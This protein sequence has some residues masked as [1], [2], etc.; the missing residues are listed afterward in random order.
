MSQDRDEL[1]IYKRICKDFKLVFDIG[2]RDDLDYYHIHPLCEYHLFEPNEEAVNS[3]IYKISNIEKYRDN[4]KINKF[5]LSDILSNNCTYYKNTQSFVPHWQGLSVDVGV[6]YS[7]QTL[8][9]YVNVNNISDIDFI[10][11]DCEELDEM[12]IRGG[13]DT[14]KHNNKV[15]YLQF[16]Y[17]KIGPMVDLLDN[18]DIYIMMTTPLLNAIKQLGIIIENIDF[19]I[20]KV[21]NQLIDIFDNKLWH[22]GVGGNVFCINKTKKCMDLSLLT[23]KI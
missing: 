17:G 3:L 20:V 1:E 5:G 7:L 16:E 14:I 13:L 22:T 19:S 23:Y 10:K 2:S 8:D 11:I 6:R 21:N 15:S 9:N 18:F 12:I 4:I